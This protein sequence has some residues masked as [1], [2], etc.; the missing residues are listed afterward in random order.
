MASVPQTEAASTTAAA[1]ETRAGADGG[2]LEGYKTTRDERRAR[3][4]A[5]KT[6]TPEEN[7]ADKAE[8]LRKCHEPHEALLRCYKDSLIP[9]CLSE[10]KEFWACFRRERGFA[11]ISISAPASAG[12]SKGDVD[13]KAE[14]S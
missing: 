8:A 11:R 14:S 4:E 7:A 12:G 13:G 9:V 6:K 1:T 3:Y 5:A 2:W 10:Y